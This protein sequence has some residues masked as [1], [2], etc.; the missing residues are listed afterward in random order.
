MISVVVHA[1]CRAPSSCTSTYYV[2]VVLPAPG[3]TP[4]RVE[5][6]TEAERS[7]TLHER[8]ADSLTGR[9]IAQDRAVN[10]WRHAILARDPFPFRE[11][12]AKGWGFSGRFTSPWGTLGPLRAPSL[13]RLGGQRTV[14]SQ[15]EAAVDSWW[16]V[17]GQLVACGLRASGS[18]SQAEGFPWRS[19]SE[20]LGPT[21]GS[22]SPPN[23]LYPTLQPGNL[24]PFLSLC[25]SIP[26]QIASNPS[27]WP[28]EASP[29]LPARHWPANWP[30]LPC[31]SAHS[32]LL[33]TWCAL[34]LSL[35]VLPL[36]ALPSSRSVE[37]RP[38]TSPV[39]R[40]MSTVRKSILPAFAG[41]KFARVC[42]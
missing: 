28:P 6:G 13:G 3:L 41:E 31:S 4:N 37:S 16:T 24:L 11:R 33:A 1:S 42:S 38:L 15:S 14:C 25:S 23:F 36:P 35:L 17:G 9:G 5:P 2:G 12:V 32:S 18:R 19:A 21:T 26:S 27:Q 40:R 22:C 30:L 29:S 10:T 34:E 20:N 39:S 7:T 8:Q